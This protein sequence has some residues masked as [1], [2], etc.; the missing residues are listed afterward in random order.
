MSI[1]A[2]GPVNVK[3]SADGDRPYTISGTLLPITGAYEPGRRATLLGDVLTLL[4]GVKGGS[5][6][7]EVKTMGTDTQGMFNFFFWR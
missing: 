6:A 1:T 3:L 5:L 4:S 2:Q 7:I